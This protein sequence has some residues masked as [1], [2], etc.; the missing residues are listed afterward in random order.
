MTNAALYGC[1]EITDM[2]V[3][4][5]SVCIMSTFFLLLVQCHFQVV[6]SHQCAITHAFMGYLGLILF[7]YFYSVLSVHVSCSSDKSNSTLHLNRND[8]CFLINLNVAPFLPHSSSIILFVLYLLS[9]LLSIQLDV[10]SSPIMNGLRRPPTC[11]AVPWRNCPLRSLR[12]KPKDCSIPPPS[13]EDRMRPAK[14]TAQVKIQTV[15]S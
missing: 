12:T 1:T 8:R 11:W 15:E 5:I 6:Q 10:G 4:I 9:F 7:L 3:L 14:V 13:E 2:S